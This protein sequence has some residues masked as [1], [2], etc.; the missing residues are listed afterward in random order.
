[1]AG[2]PDSKQRGNRIVARIFVYGTLLRGFGNHRLLASAKFVGEAM[3]K[4]QYTMINLGAFP[5]ILNDGTTALR[6]EVYDVNAET[7]ARLDQLEGNGYF[8]NRQPIE[9]KTKLG[10]VQAYFLLR[11]ISGELKVVSSGDWRCT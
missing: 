3:T 2:D 8:Y 5:A 7:L 9:L 4:P 10:K 11:E 1:M 6:G